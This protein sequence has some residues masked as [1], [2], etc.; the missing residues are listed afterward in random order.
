M[1]PEQ[2]DSKSAVS[3]RV[4]QQFLRAFGNTPRVR[5]FIDLFE[6]LRIIHEKS[7]H[8]EEN[9][10][11]EPEDTNSDLGKRFRTSYFALTGMVEGTLA[12]DSLA[13]NSKILIPIL[14]RIVY[15]YTGLPLSLWARVAHSY[16]EMLK[17]VAADKDV[18]CV[19]GTVPSGNLRWPQLR[20][21]SDKQISLEILRK[22]DPD[23]YAKSMQSNEQ[24]RIMD[25]NIQA[26]IRRDGL[27]MTK[28]NVMGRVLFMGVDKATGEKIVYD[29]DG[30]RTPME[31]YVVELK[32]KNLEH[33]ELTRINIR[34][35]DGARTLDKSLLPL[36]DGKPEKF[37][38]LTDDP[39]KMTSVTKVYPVIN[40][41]GIDYVS[42][43]RFKGFAVS[44]LINKAGR[45]IEGSITFYDFETGRLTKRETK[46]PDGSVNIRRQQEPYVTLEKG[47]LLLTVPTSMPWTT[48][49]NAVRK[50]SE[51]MPS[52]EYGE[53]SRNS[54]FRF[55]AKDFALVKEALGGLAMSNTAARFIKDYYE[56]L[57]KAEEA[58]AGDLSKFESLGTRPLFG[59]VK[60]GVAWLEANG[61]KGICALDTG[62][63]KTAT[64][65]TTCLN[66]M[67]RGKTSEG[68]RRFLFVCDKALAGNFPK[69]ACKIIEDEA[70]LDD[71]LKITDIITYH[72]YALRRSKD[73]TYGDDYVAI[74]FDEAHQ[75]L[76]D[77]SSRFYKAAVQTKC[78]RK[79]ILTASP[80]E[81]SPRNVFC[82]ASIA[83]NIDLS[84]P[85]GRKRE[86]QFTDQ[87]AE[88]VGGR[89]VGVKK[90]NPL[91]LI[92][93]RTWVKRNLFFADKR[94]VAEINLPPVTKQ[95][96]TVTME[97]E[98]EQ[99]YRKTM[100]NLLKS[101]KDI[102]ASTY[103]GNTAIT[104]V[105]EK[106]H[107]RKALQ[108]LSA[109]S[110]T[111]GRVIPG[112]TSPKLSQAAKIVS[113]HVSGKVLL[114]TDSNHM[115]QEALAKMI[116]EFPGRGH[117]VAYATKIVY[118]NPLGKEIVYKQ[119][120]ME[121]PETG[122]KRPAEEW[123]TI[124]LQKILQKD[125]MVLTTI[126]TSKY[127]TGQNLQ[128]YGTIIHLDRDTWSN[129]T[130][131]QRDGRSWRSGQKQPVSS[132]TLDVVYEESKNNEKTLD[133]IRSVIQNMDEK[134]FDEI[135]IESQQQR[136]G[137]EWAEIRK[138]RSALHHI[139]KKMMERALS[140]Y[141]QDLGENDASDNN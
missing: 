7:I 74:F 82:L 66:L 136:L 52:V 27:D 29:D 72:S 79:V 64:A 34:N 97:P 93:F 30:S 87:F 68:N 76:I 25:R 33:K 75:Y 137:V 129:E 83:N 46:N 113:E 86:R 56:D 101:L 80:V 41:Y 43:G 22:E 17:D 134:L 70:V 39:D 125:P 65:I 50:L 139:D 23:L 130:M 42:A 122:K 105:E 3:R 91:L 36:L 67:R 44:D 1:N 114:F 20:A 89:I 5:D 121:D 26:Q 4:R 123:A 103:G 13:R 15:P 90:S 107:V 6:E 115:A 126:L 10:D 19:L 140:P 128:S 55:P 116:S 62:L 48:T 35:L 59:V 109:L 9:E 2:F 12:Q 112:A 118:V 141:A 106:S 49:R 124:V 8:S 45:L 85:E 73:P 28:A 31:E 96:I 98:V 51:V 16:A 32:K 84:T 60:Q 119:A 40:L 53:G 138:Q 14:N 88:K 57:I 117:A 131:K 69:E 92:D 71:L 58:A 108:L 11:L 37:V 110:D 99:A 78:P 47:Q 61:D 94:K 63:G 135:V 100:E 95:N 102:Q 18:Y 77:P 54:V 81:N 120:V 133:E 24:R 132:Y 21:A 104:I 127:A 38:S 111:P